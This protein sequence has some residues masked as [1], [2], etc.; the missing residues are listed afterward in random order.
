MA[1]TDL[2]FLCSSVSHQK[3]KNG[4]WTLLPSIWSFIRSSEATVSPIWPCCL[5]GQLLVLGQHDGHELDWADL[6]TG[7]AVA[8]SWTGQTSR[9]RESCLLMWCL[10]ELAVTASV[11][12]QDSSKWDSGYANLACQRLL[13]W[14]VK[15][16]HFSFFILKCIMTSRPRKFRKVWCTVNF[17]FFV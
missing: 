2:T 10:T 1:K 16:G 17:D 11:L 6:C 13:V 5:R 3:T 7:T 9:Y 4:L 15:Y 14:L 8:V 12:L